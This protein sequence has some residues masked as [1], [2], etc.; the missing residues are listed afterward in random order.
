MRIWG[1]GRGSVSAGVMVEMNGLELHE[2]RPLRAKLTARACA[3]NRSNYKAAPEWFP[4]LEPCGECPGVG[5]EGK[6]PPPVRVSNPF[7]P[8][9]RR[10]GGSPKEKTDG[11]A[12]QSIK[13]GAGLKSFTPRGRGVAPRLRAGMAAALADL[14][15]FKGEYPPNLEYTLAARYNLPVLL[16]S[17][18]IG[19]NEGL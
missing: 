11:Q 8:H 4:L 19:V 18:I 14:K 7:N 5:G 1:R 15:K 9:D 10:V 2:C 6:E 17:E 13:S 16:V 12:P 3:L